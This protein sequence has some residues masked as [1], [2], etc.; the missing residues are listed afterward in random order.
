VG[1]AEVLELGGYLLSGVFLHEVRGA[2]QQ[3]RA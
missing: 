1:G 3:N 2:G